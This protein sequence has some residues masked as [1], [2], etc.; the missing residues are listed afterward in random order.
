MVLCD[1][2]VTSLCQK[3]DPILMGEKVK[4]TLEAKPYDYPDIITNTRDYFLALWMGSNEF[5]T[6]KTCDEKVYKQLAEL[7]EISHP[8]TGQTLSLLRRTTADGKARRT[9][10]GNSSACSSYANPEAAD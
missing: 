4:T 8:K 9:S 7:K 2:S 10:T 6:A 3:G 5:T 1:L